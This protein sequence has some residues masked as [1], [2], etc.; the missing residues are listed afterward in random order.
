[1]LETANKLSDYNILH[2]CG[3]AHHKNNLSWYQDYEAKAYNWATFTEGVTIEEGRRLFPG[4]CVLGG[5]D[6][7]PQTLIDSG[8]E[9]EV[10]K[11]VDQLIKENGHRGYI[12]GADCSIPE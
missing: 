5:F 11:F 6:N 3:Y 8:S 4:K 7:N 9:E 12:M 2:I 1:M 10:C